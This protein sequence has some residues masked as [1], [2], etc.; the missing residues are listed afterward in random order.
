MG[1]E[2]WGKPLQAVGHSERPWMKSIPGGNSRRP[3][4]LENS[5]PEGVLLHDNGGTA[6]GRILWVLVKHCEVF[7]CYQGSSIPSER[8]KPELP[9]LKGNT[10]GHRDRW[11]WKLRAGPLPGLPLKAPCLFP[12]TGIYSLC[13]SLFTLFFSRS[14]SLMAVSGCQN[15]SHRPWKGGFSPEVGVTEQ[16]FPNTPMLFRA[17]QMSVDC[18]MREGW[19]RRKT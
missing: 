7:D 12:F 19:E 14:K 15:L 8:Q 13:R 3:V 9:Y 1:L 5:T 17:W 6:R 10:A 2:T 18:R 11:V 4:W 16:K